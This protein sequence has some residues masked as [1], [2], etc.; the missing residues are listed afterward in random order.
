MAKFVVLQVGKD[1]RYVVSSL[2]P[3][4][5]VSACQTQR[6]MADTYP[7]WRFVVATCTR[8]IREQMP[9]FAA[10]HPHVPGGMQKLAVKLAGNVGLTFAA[11]F[12]KSLKPGAKK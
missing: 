7:M 8:T 10:T 6:V 9:P 2:R 11:N 5:Y 1:G 12:L 4:D 3:I